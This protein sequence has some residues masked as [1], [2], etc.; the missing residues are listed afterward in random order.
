G[1]VCIS[2][3]VY[4]H[5]HNKFDVAFVDL[6]NQQLK[7][8][9]YPVHAYLMMAHAAAQSRGRR[10]ATFRWVGLV[11]LL[12]LAAIAMLLVGRGRPAPDEHLAAGPSATKTREG[13]EI[14][15]RVALGVMPFKSLGGGAEDWRREALRDGLNTQ[16]SQLSH[17]KV[18]SKEFLDFLISRKG[19]TE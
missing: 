4:L 16:L 2:E 6:G 10:P 12:A 18:Y 1:T 7:N 11:V 19:L 5:V 3:G 9:T 14:E 17:V 15:A 13:S 8:I